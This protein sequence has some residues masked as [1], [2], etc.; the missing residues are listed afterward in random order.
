MYHIYNNYLIL[1]IRKLAIY[2]LPQ[3]YSVLPYNRIYNPINLLFHFGFVLFFL[4]II[5]NKDFKNEN[6]IILSPILGSLIISLLFFI[7]YRWR[8]YA[9]PFMILTTIILFSKFKRLNKN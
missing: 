4:K 1:Q 8:Y 7:G 2:F 6:F 5:A 9:E 3:N